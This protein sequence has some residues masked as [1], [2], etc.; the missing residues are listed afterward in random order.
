M[1]YR[2]ADGKFFGDGFIIK[3]N[4]YRYLWN[5]THP[6]AHADG[7]VAEHR[8]VVFDAGVDV[9]AGSIVHHRNGD[10][11]DNRL[12]NLAVLTRSEH[13]RLH[14]ASGESRRPR[15]PIDL[16]L[17]ASRRAG[18]ATWAA[19]GRELGVSAMTVLRRAKEAA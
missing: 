18:G 3:N 16:A 13:Q 9:P 15:I 10:Q 7:Y 14:C 12:E 11:L 4:G 19:I 5:P 1:K 8:A 2:A 6:L 17:V